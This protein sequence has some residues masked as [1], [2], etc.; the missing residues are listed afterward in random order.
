MK[1]IKQNFKG[2]LVGVIVTALVIGSVFAAPALETINIARGG[3]N[4]LFMDMPMELVDDQGNPIEPMIY[5][6]RTF[7]PLRAM[8][9]T[10]GFVV[11]WDS[12]NYTV[13]VIGHITAKHILVE[14]YEQA[15]VIQ[16]ALWAGID[17]D[18]LMWEFSIDPGTAMF[19]GGYTFGRGEMIPEFE[20]A[21][22]AL[23]VGEIS[24]I[25]PSVFG[26][27]IIKRVR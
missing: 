6:D 18:E 17:F 24:E 16:L 15:E 4:V 27:H 22:F 26:Y 11:E 21:A 5:N 8:M 12:D 25:V 9:E 19:P 7:I 1:I 14:T 23:A 2:F 20:D 13:Y 10:F 3:I